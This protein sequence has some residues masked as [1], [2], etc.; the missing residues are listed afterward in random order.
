MKLLSYITAGIL[1]V[2]ASSLNAQNC[3]I[4]LA[5]LPMI[6][7]ED[8]PEATE[9]YLLTRLSQ[10]LTAEGI[11]TD[12]LQSQFF[13]SAKFNHITEDVTPGP[14]VQTALHTYLTL[15]MGDTASETIY[16]TSTLELRGVGTSDQRAFINALRGLNAKN[17]KVASFIKQ[18]KSKILDY[19]NKNYRSI[20]AK[21]NRAAA[22]NDYQQALWHLVSIPE[23]CN[24]YNEALSLEHKYFQAYIDQVGIK[25]YSAALAKWSASPD[26]VGAEEAFAY[27]LQIDPESSAYGKAVKLA[28]EMKASVKSDRDFE[29]REKYHDKIDLEKS[30]INA[31]REVGVAY[32]KGQQPTTTNLMWVK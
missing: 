30:R 6:Q 24:G 27:L 5:V 19:F 21:A 13:I 28:A 14:P 31:I 16:A 26:N 18:G 10:M 12:P 20:I 3:E 2:C 15:Y 7:G 17:Q 23:C 25:L 8:V 29:L 32:G 22:Q 9:D 4:N 11:T 1:S